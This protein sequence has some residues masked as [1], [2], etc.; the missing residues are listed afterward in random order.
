MAAER[1]TEERMKELSEKIMKG[2]DL[3]YQRLLISKQK[4]DGELVFY[5]DGKIV[6]VKARDL[7][8]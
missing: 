4:D 8:K 5:K 1:M 3:A 2:L 7:T 6:T